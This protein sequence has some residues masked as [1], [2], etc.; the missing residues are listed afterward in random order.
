MDEFAAFEGR[1]ESVYDAFA[2]RWVE[3]WVLGAVRGEAGEVDGV[4]D[5]VDAASSADECFVDGFWACDLSIN[6]LF[7][8]SRPECGRHTPY[9]ISTILQRHQSRGTFAAANHGREDHFAA[10]V[11]TILGDRDSLR[12]AACHDMC[13][14]S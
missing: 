11:D 4:C 2:L 5:G 10:V 9:E 13:K 1:V 7:S 12:H 6:K 14:C 3:V 8:D